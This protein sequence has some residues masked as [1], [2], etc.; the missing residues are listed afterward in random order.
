MDIKEMIEKDGVSRVFD[1][2]REA[3]RTYVYDLRRQG[4]ISFSSPASGEVPSIHIV[5]RTLPEVWEDTIMALMAVGQ[6]VHTGYDPHENG[7]YISFPS[8]E[9]TVMMHIEEPFREP[10]FHKNF[11]GG[12]MGF[13]DYKAEIEGVK[14][15]WMISPEVVV[16]MI[17]KGKF[18][19]IED[20]KRWKYTYHQR[21]TAYPYLDIEAKSRTIN[22]ID[23][24]I[25]KLKKEPLSKSAQAVTWDPRWDHNDG[26]MGVKWKDYDSPCLQRAWFRLV[27]F[28][29]GYKLNLNDHWRSRCHLKGVPHNIFGFTEGIYEPVRLRL[30]E[31]LGVPIKR[32]RYVDINDSLHL[33]GHYF[34]PRRQGQDAERILNEIFKIASGEPLEQRLII[35]GTP[36][37]DMMVEEIEAEYKKRIEN[38]GYGGGGS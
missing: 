33:Y 6:T 37:H 35:P 30:Q 4:K 7:E 1:K 12:W 25:R 22:Q 36:L 9:A 29:Q 31:E 23:S 38:P 8:M 11:L 20:D 32:G 14:D 34:D 19:E 15:H 10:R 3:A 27:P 16:E 28:E 2:A 21:L 13:G 18:D 24:V 5:R 17:K 26:Q